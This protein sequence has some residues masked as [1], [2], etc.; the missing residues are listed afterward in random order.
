MIYIIEFMSLHPSGMF[1]GAAQKKKTGKK[2]MTIKIAMFAF[3]NLVVIAFASATGQWKLVYSPASRIELIPLVR[4]T[5]CL[6]S[7]V[8]LLALLH[9]LHLLAAVSELLLW[10]CAPWSSSYSRERQK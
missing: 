3:Y 9:L 7:A 2:V 4:Y 8:H 5:K 10:E 1:F 6:K